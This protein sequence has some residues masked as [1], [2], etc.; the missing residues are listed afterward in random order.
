MRAAH[1]TCT[2]AGL[3]LADTVYLFIGLK[4]QLTHKT[5]NLIFQLVIVDCK[6]TI[7]W[8]S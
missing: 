1:A 7:L 2:R 3:T 8:E 4:S 5:V 6:L